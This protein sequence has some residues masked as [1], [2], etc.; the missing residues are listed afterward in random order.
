MSTIPSPAH[1]QN[2][3]EVKVPEYTLPDP[4]VAEDGET[5]RTADQWFSSRRKEILEH[6]RREVYGRIPPTVVSPQLHVIE[7]GT[8]AL[9]GSALRSQVTIR[10]GEEPSSPAIDS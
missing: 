5:V 6:F 3:E 4:L 7:Q 9:D 8:P 10:L 1:G 2:Y